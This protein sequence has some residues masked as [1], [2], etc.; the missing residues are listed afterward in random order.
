MQQ[1]DEADGEMSFARSS[2]DKHGGRA[3]DDG[4]MGES[5]CVDGEA[6][7]S[8]SVDITM[9]SGSEGTA[10]SSSDL[11]FVVPDGTVMRDSS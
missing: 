10:E 11:L 9:T 6:D 4:E 5:G 1:H 8:G 2:S 3:T 7:E